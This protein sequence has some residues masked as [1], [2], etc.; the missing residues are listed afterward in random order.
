VVFE[1]LPSCSAVFVAELCRLGY[2][3]GL[4]CGQMFPMAHASWWLA[5]DG[6]DADGPT[7]EA[8]DRF[9]ATRRADGYRLYDWRASTTIDE[10]HTLATTVETWWPEIESLLDT[11]ITNAK[12]ECLNRLVRQ[13]KRSGCGSR[14]VQNQHRRVRFHCTRTARAATGVSRSL[15]AQ[16]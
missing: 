12:A 9:L 7:P 13:V 10:L 2:T 16:V 4:A 8:A 14:N 3:S 11:V 15:P 5:A 1:R 6:L